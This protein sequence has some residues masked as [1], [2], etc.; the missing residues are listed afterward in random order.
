[1]AKG[2]ARRRP[3]LGCLVLVANLPSFPSVLVSGFDR[4]QRPRFGG[5]RARI[6]QSPPGWRLLP[7][8]NVDIP[9]G[10]S[11]FSQL[12]S[13]SSRSFEYL[14]LHFARR[15]RAGLAIMIAD[16]KLSVRSRTCSNIRSVRGRVRLSK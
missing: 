2:E 6:I 4:A 5:I 15:L 9:F 10:Y 7:S 13:R 8:S 12:R 1:M 14:A 16:S 3:G 11:Q